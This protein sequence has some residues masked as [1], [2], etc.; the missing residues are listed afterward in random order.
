MIPISE[1]SMGL[2]KTYQKYPPRKLQSESYTGPLTITQYQ[3]FQYIRDQLE[4]D[5]FSL[6]LPS[7]N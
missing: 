6:S 5:G 4:K 7:G 1:A 2:M 3:R